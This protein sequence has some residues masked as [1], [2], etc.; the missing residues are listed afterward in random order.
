ML[1]QHLRN[2]YHRRWESKSRRF[3]Y[4]GGYAESSAG[5]ATCYYLF[6][7]DVLERPTCSL[8]GAEWGSA[9]VGHGE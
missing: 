6:G 3:T 1:W 9:F 7:I 5:L 8:Q 2:V 4:F